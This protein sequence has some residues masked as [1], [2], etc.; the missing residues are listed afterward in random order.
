MRTL[1]GFLTGLIFLVAAPLNNAQVG[2]VLRRAQDKAQKAKK[3]ADIY[4]PWTSGT[5]A[6]TGRSRS[7]KDGAH[8]RAVRK[9]RDDAVRKSGGQHGDP[10][11]QP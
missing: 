10:A 1:S 9:S 3:V 6:R 8:F 4:K 5:R 7:R 11:S 2:D